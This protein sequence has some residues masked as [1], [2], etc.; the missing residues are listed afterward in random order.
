MDIVFRRGRA[1]AH[2]VRDDMEAPP[3]YSAVRALMRVLEDKGQ[4]SH[5][6]EGPRYVYRPT[7]ERGRAGQSALARL[8]DTFFSG[9]TAQTVAT[10]LELE[11][12]SLSDEELDA[13]GEM[14]ERARAERSEGPT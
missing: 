10:L 5:S 14:I 1:T 11:G 8:V 3:S 9:S 7:V 13:L 6:Q 2:E 12:R 4:L